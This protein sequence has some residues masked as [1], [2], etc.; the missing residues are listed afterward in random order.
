MIIIPTSLCTNMLNKIHE[1]HLGIEKCKRRA[2][3]VMCWPHINQDVSNMVKN[4]NSCLRYQRKA[5]NLQPHSTPNH[6]WE[7]VGPDLFTVH[8]RNYILNVD[9]FS[10]FIKVCILSSTTSS[11]VIENMQSVFSQG[12]PVKY[13]LTMN[14]ILQV[15]SLNTSQQIGISYI[16][17]LVHTTHSPTDLLNVQ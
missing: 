13:L 7:K 10:Q 11:T 6:A 15:P 9:I 3:E 5:G 8:G 14:Y 1:G 12:T 16:Q 2:R 17:H 4:C